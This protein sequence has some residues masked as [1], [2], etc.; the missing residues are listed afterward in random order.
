MPLVRPLG[1][2]SKLVAIYYIVI[3]YCLLVQLTTQLR[4]FSSIQQLL[5]VTYV[6]YSLSKALT[7]RSQ[8]TTFLSIMR[9][10]LRQELVMLKLFR[11]S[12]R[13]R[14]AL[15]LT[16]K[17]PIEVVSKAYIAQYR[18]RLTECLWKLASVL[19]RNRIY[20]NS[21]YYYNPLTH[22]VSLLQQRNIACLVRSLVLEYSNQEPI[23]GQS[24]LSNAS[25]YVYKIEILYALVR[26]IYIK[27]QIADKPI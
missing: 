24:D 17:I 5:Y 8:T 3:F 21:S 22:L 16:R 2:M 19:L 12:N 14:F 26:I 25:V 18:T 6:C 20:C 10:I 27:E 7:A 13:R 23:L 15:P 1:G 11:T 4:L 9:Q